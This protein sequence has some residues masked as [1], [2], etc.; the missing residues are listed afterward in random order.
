MQSSLIAP[1]LKA[2]VIIV[3]VTY[4]SHALASSIVTREIDSQV[5]GRKWSFN[6]YL[7]TGYE[8]SSDTY[9]VLYLLHGNTHN[10]KSWTVDG[11]IQETADALIAGGE[12]P[13]AI[14]VMPDGA[15]TWYV[16]RKEPM[17]SAILKELIPT[18]EKEYRVR[19]ER[20]G[21]VIAGLSMGGYGAMRF[22]LRYPEMFAAA[23]LLSPAVY[24]PA[25]PENSSARR[26]GVFGSP[27]FDVEVWKSLSYPALWDAYAAKQLPVPM[28][29]VTGDDDMFRIE[30]SATDFYGY[31]RDR[32]QPAELRI[33]DGGHR[34]SVWSST[35]GDAMKYIFRFTSKDAG[36]PADK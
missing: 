16:D 34:W 1:L 27:D 7:P 21:R 26:A 15:T 5:L 29:I 18:V 8:K 10:Y 23:G 30:L 31:L 36:A 13:A 24:D 32:K 4:G 6:V 22:A 20:S 3:L 11:H 9:P 2:F 25:P 35:I 33:V 14:I 19:A 17:E 12:I 28:Y